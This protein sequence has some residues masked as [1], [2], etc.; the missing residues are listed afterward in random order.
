MAITSNQVS[1]EKN[2]LVA[3]ATEKNKTKRQMQIE[4]KNCLEKAGRYLSGNGKHVSKI[5]SLIIRKEALKNV[6]CDM[7]L[8]DTLLFEV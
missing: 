4:F 5:S 6:T 8:F 3:T 7:E 1:F 2:S